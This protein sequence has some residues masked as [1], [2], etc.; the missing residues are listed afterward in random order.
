MEEKTLTTRIGKCPECGNENIIKDYENGEYVCG[1]CGL[2]IGK[3][4]DRGPEWRAFDEEQKEKRPRTGA[5][6]TYTIHD[7]GLSTI[8][9]SSDQD[10]YG[11][12]LG[13][14]QKEVFHRLRKWQVRT[15]VSDGLERSLAF[16]LGEIDKISGQG[17]L[18][19]PKN[20]VENASLIFRKVAKERISRGRSI[21]G[22][23]AAS[24][25]LSCRQLGIPRSLE[26]VSEV[27][28]VEKREVAKDYRTIVKEI[29]YKL[30]VPSPSSYVSRL[31]NEFG[32]FGK[33]E[34]IAYKILSAARQVK[35]TSG[36]GP[37]SLA[38][39][40]VY[41]ASLLTGERVTQQDVAE[42]MRCTEVTI[43]NR[44]RELVERLLFVVEL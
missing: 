11:K 5:P 35:L 8:I 27:S 17:Y 14:E 32:I 28:G 3:I 7:K 33:T 1:G 42:R 43:R 40:A 24:I 25:Y 13:T 38:A 26:E 9:D 37:T 19:L 10:V 6:L 30:P 34:E 29:G 41:T 22:V 15:R 23:V 18:N 20:A 2:V 16:G 12:P 31:T 44:Y 36:R 4:Y 21:K 39:A